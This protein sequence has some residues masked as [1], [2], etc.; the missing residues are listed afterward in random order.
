MGALL[1]ARHYGLV[2][3]VRLLSRSLDPERHQGHEEVV[4][5]RAAWPD[6]HFGTEVAH[7]WPGLVYHCLVEIGR[8][9]NAVF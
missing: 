1:C 9:S 8:R 4:Q 2:A 3:E 7:L 5:G 6:D